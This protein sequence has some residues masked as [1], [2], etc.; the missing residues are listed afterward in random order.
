ME[1]VVARFWEHAKGYYK[2][3]DGSQSSETES[4]RQALRPLRRLFGGTPAKDFGPKRFKAVRDEMV[5]MGWCRTN[6]NRQAARV[7]Q[8]FKWATEE[9]LVPGVVLHALKAVRG[10]RPHTDNVKESAPVKPVTEHAVDAV[11]PLVSR[12]V[13]ALIDLQLHTGMRPGEA[14][15]MRA[16]DLADLDKKVWLYRPPRHKT[17]HHG[18]A[19]E[20]L[21]GPKAQ[22][23][24]RP[25]FTTNPKAY[26][27]SPRDADAEAGVKGGN[28]GDRYTVASYRRAIARACDEAFPLTPDLA[29]MARRARQWRAAYA[30]VNGKRLPL[31]KCPPRILK[32]WEAVN[33][34]LAANR[35]HPHQL[36][37]TFATA[38]RATH[39]LEVAQILLGHADTKTTL[40]YAEQ[41]TRRAM[42]V[43]RE[44]G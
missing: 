39:G 21:I 43:M 30:K 14:V 3:A 1:E 7:R 22:E 36:R 35:W 20:I 12:Q 11:R 34:F 37:H 8:V 25:F 13:A 33:D 41:D 16:A 5:R 23:V 9:E 32:M 29:H 4:F 28:P 19:R 26:L 38:I 6:V 42:E 24:L 40:Q 31:K 10:L 15:I 17:A 44:V 27:F 18:K 2:L